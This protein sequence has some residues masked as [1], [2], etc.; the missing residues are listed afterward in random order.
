MV[1]L[2]AKRT[3]S[4]HNFSNREI[5]NG[6]RKSVGMERK[7]LRQGAEGANEVLQ[8]FALSWIAGFL[9]RAPLDSAMSVPVRLVNCGAHRAR[10][11]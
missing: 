1:A 9:I 5:V 6:A 8:S 10:V 4:V 2:R 3:R 11:R 7:A